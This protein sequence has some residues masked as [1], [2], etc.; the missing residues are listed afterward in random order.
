M[1]PYL[2]VNLFRWFLLLAFLDIISLSTIIS[3]GRFILNRERVRM[4]IM[5][6]ISFK[7]LLSIFQLIHSLPIV[8][9]M[10]MFPRFPL[11]EVLSHFV[12]GIGPIS[13]SF[14]KSELFHLTNLRL[15]NGD[16]RWI[17]RFPWVNIDRTPVFPGP[18]LVQRFFHIPVGINPSGNPTLFPVIKII[19]L[20]YGFGRIQEFFLLWTHYPIMWLR[21]REPATF[22]L[23]PKHIFLGTVFP[24]FLRIQSAC[25]LRIGTNRFRSRRVAHG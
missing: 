16:S 9:S 2:N 3:P 22:F 15:V 10:R 12:F 4:M 21:L 8:G 17:C 5:P 11:G 24:R 7:D 6:M 20:P 14:D 23:I 25:A 18:S 13:P 19:P 1:F